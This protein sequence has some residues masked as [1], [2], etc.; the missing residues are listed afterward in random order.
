MKITFKPD[1]SSILYKL[2]VTL[3]SYNHHIPSNKTEFTC[4]NEGIVSHVKGC[5]NQ[6]ETSSVFNYLDSKQTN[7][8]KQTIANAEHNKNWSC[9]FDVAI[10]GI[11]QWIEF[12]GR[13]EIF[14][15][16]NI[17]GYGFASVASDKIRELENSR[18]QLASLNTLH[19]LIINFSNELVQAKPDEVHQAVNITLKRLG[20]YAA[21]DRVYIFE[22]LPAEDVVNNTYEWCGEG[23]TPEIDNLQGIPFEAVPRWKEKF[24]RKEYVYIPLVS[25]ISEE[26]HVEKEILEPQGIISLLALP[27]YYGENLYGFIGFDSVKHQREWSAEH[28]NLLRLAGNII[29]GTLNRASFEKAIIA[30]RQEAEDANRAKSEFLATMSHEI[31]TPMNAILGF[32]EV[33]HNNVTDQK[34]KNYVNAILNSGRILLA[35]IN[36]ILDLSKIESGQM[37]LAEEPVDVPILA[38][39]IVQLFQP[40]TVEKGIYLHTE[41][42]GQF[43]PALI[44]DE[45]RLRQ[46]LFNLVGNAVKFTETGGVLIG[47]HINQLENSNFYDLAIKVHDTGI[48][49]P[50]DKID[51][52]FQSFYQVDSNTTRKYGGTGLGLAIAQKLAN[53]M[54][55]II[56]VK[57]EPGRG[58]T[59]SVELPA[60]EAS[61]GVEAEKTLLDWDSE[62]V[63]FDKS[64]LL[65]IDDVEYNRELVKNYLENEK[66]EV[67]QA[68][69]GQQG[70]DLCRQFKPDAVLMDLRMPGMNGY[71]A[72]EIIRSDAQ[73]AHIPVIAFTASSMKHEDEKINKMFSGYIRKPVSRS[74]LFRVL[75]QFLPHSSVKDQTSNRDANSIVALQLN[76]IQL[77]LNDYDSS[78]SDQLNQLRT[79]IEPDIAE[80]FSRHLIFTVRQYGISPLIDLSTHLQSAIQNFDFGQFQTSLH[81]LEKEIG[82]LRN[83]IDKKA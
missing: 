8:L 59:F 20:E 82:L 39:E 18:E 72:T 21:V 6:H 58:S 38:Q 12:S 77:F 37:Q 25:E 11:D 60:L 47:L 42:S 31:R 83:I 26:Y 30:A 62:T 19:D 27:M 70:V 52:I 54:G 13:H 36:D 68:A 28:I 57:S 67:I 51:R 78:L 5:D 35:L 73:T 29:A 66:I 53:L 17:S 75:K 46:I 79:F 44:T 81:Q 40:K 34:S 16:G 9:G 2:P 71:E 24:S 3:F 76:Q 50:Q 41:V 63:V 74:E 64:L 80:Q 48:G 4:L 65:I 10:K 43:P 61:S 56:R 33:L 14:T 1:D 15:D 49:I 32:S 45:V 22:Y 55:G 23:I 69:N 7:H